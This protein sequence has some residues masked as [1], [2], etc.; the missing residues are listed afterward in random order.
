MASKLAVVREVHV[1]CLVLLLLLLAGN[2]GAQ[3]LRFS[4]GEEI[5]YGAYYNMSFIWVN[6]GELV[7]KADTVLDKGKLTWLLQAKGR[8]Y[9]NYD[10]FFGVRDTFY[11]YL[12]YP[13]FKPKYFYRA[14]NHGGKS[15]RL[16][17]R[18]NTP[19]GK[20]QYR[21]ETNK[22]ENKQSVLEQPKGVYDLLSQA[23]LLRDWNWESMTEGESGEFKTL[24]DHRVG[25]FHMRYLGK[26]QIETRNKR[27]FNC[28]K[29]SIRVM[30][31]DFFPEGDD[32]LVWYSADENHIPVMVETK[33][34]IGSV[35]AIL[36]DA[37]ALTYPLNSEI[38]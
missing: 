35:K 29:V 8:S 1:S 26:E 20:I 7:F 13:D 38:H 14:V 10:W 3:K 25:N 2:A 27:S 5:K 31:G 16:W 9:S 12:S 34:Q 30:E 24:I 32:M 22:D 23:Y 6:A 11:T 18:F 21:Y 37:K 33:F 17:Y 36:L 4:P 28:Y 15:S 19:P